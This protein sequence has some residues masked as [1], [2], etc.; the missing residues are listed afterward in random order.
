M[1]S[2]SRDVAT[3]LLVA[4]ALFMEI[5]DATVITTAIP[6][7][8]RDFSVP[9]AHLSIGVSA[10]LVAVTLFIP[11]SGFIADKFGAQ[12]I[13]ISAIIIFTFASVLCGISTSLIEF[14]LARILQGVGGAMMVPVGRLVVLRDLPKEKL[15]K[16]VAI[17]T[18]P[19]LSAPLLGP[20][21]GGYIA[22]HFSWQWIFFMNV[23]LG[24]IAVVASMRLLK[25]TKAP[26][27]KFDVKG[28]LLTGIGF[29]SFM[30][31]IEY[32]AGNTDAVATSLG[33]IGLGLLLMIFAVLHVLKAP[34]PLFSFDAMQHRTFRLGVYGGSVVRIALGSAPFLVPL[35]L[36]L[37]MGYT[38]VE[39]GSLLLWLFAGNLAIKPAT[40]WI[41]NAFGFKRV[42]VVNGILIS[43]GFVALAFV[44]PDTSRVAVASLL[45]ING[46]TRSM[47]LTLLNTIA[48]ADVPTHKM[49][50][51]NTLSAILMQM[52]RGL[53]ITL[54]AL[55]IAGAS[56]IL[57]TPA[58]SPSLN[59]FTIALLFMAL[60]ALVSIADSLML[61]K[62]DGDAVL[63]KRL[64]KQAK[65]EA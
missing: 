43:L 56:L 36:Q 49:R 1:K 45:F 35:M 42:L 30:A 6:V 19:A 44:N 63:N 29:A 40:T 32:L 41:M 46:V 47:H 2:F 25:N 11:L 27:G 14:T 17:I 9:A 15:V 57:G 33:I 51:A 8:A 20:V 18:W 16:T 13:F 26:V 28:F 62:K 3:A 59:T 54:S 7:I 24:L 21:L 52:N 34:N 5:L 12:T 61:S 23:P 31:G 38:P 50:D 55:A 58:E 4:G 22:T 53:G 60:L 10:Y 37:G 65:K 64:R 39:A 48:F